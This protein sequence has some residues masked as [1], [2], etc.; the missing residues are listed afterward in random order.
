MFSEHWFPNG[1]TTHPA[2]RLT[3]IVRASRLHAAELRHLPQHVL[4]DIETAQRLVARGLPRSREAR[5]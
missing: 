3:A 5:A 2:L 1:L 4:D